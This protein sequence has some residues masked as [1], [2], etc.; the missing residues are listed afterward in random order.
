MRLGIVGCGAIAQQSHLPAVTKLREVD[1]LVVVD[2]DAEWVGQ[3]RKRFGASRAL[4]DYRELVG[5][6]D[7]AVVATP[8]WTHVEIAS[9]LLQHGIHVLCEKPVALS[10]TDAACLFD[11]AARAGTRLMAGHSRRFTDSA[12]ALHRLL[13]LGTLG[14]VLE[15]TAALG[16]P[17][18]RWPAR[19][20]FRADPRLAGGGCLMDSGVHL[21]DLVL[22]LFDEAWE[23]EDYRASGPRLGF[24]D[25]ATLVLRFESGTRARLACSYSHDMAGVLDVKADNGWARLPINGTPGLEFFGRAT[26]P[27]RSAGALQVAIDGTSAFER[28]LRHFLD[29][30]RTNEPFLVRGAEVVAG[31]RV[32]EECYARLAG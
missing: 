32:V 21:I 28:Q 22:W 13:S 24:E 16:V 18:R 15:V 25:D 31:L 29:C 3:V 10:P 19:H 5:A 6:V 23:V 4:R 11:V 12:L 2:T 30:V 20:A 14:H 1:E 7:V 27:G 26:L 8:N 17:M 9:F